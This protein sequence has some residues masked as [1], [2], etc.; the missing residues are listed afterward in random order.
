MTTPFLSTTHCCLSSRSPGLSCGVWTREDA[1]S[2]LI[3]GSS[4]NVEDLRMVTKKQELITN[5]FQFPVTQGERRLAQGCWRSWKCWQYINEVE[6]IIS[7]GFLKNC[8]QKLQLKAQNGRN[9]RLFQLIWK[10]GQGEVRG[11]CGMLG[12]FRY[13]DMYLYLYNSIFLSLSLSLFTLSFCPLLVFGLA[14]P[15]F[16]WQSGS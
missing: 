5:D 16:I 1:V 6:D 15:K 2:N 14:N 13:A 3:S 12:F 11:L 10:G 9:Q 7:L 4:K 8:A